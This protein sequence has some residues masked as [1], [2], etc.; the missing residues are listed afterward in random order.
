M[1]ASPHAGD[2]RGP[3]PPQPD[4][5]VVVSSI[6]CGGGRGGRLARMCVVATNVRCLAAPHGPR[7]GTGPRP[8][9][10]RRAC[11]PGKHHITSS[12]AAALAG[13][14]RPRSVHEPLDGSAE[15]VTGGICLRT[16]LRRR[17]PFAREVQAKPRE[18]AYVRVLLLLPT[19]ARALLLP[20]VLRGRHGAGEESLLRHGEHVSTA[21]TFLSSSGPH[22]KCRMG[23][24]V[25][26]TWFC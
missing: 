7:R 4:I 3:R 2:R 11:R 9:P 8:G 13:W 25:P 20:A 26:N 19:G 22:A 15:P 16:P 14:W 6:S 24:V 21:G 23:C 5:N 12:A 17:H 1:R 10:A 18:A